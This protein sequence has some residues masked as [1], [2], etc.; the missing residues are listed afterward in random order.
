[1]SY[2][3]IAELLKYHPYG[4]QAYEDRAG[5]TFVCSRYRKGFV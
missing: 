4:L 5:V 3:N 1:M 2:H